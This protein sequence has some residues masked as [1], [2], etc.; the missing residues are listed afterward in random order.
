MET[1]I[2]HSQKENLHELMPMS[3]PENLPMGLIMYDQDLNVLDWNQQAEVI[4]GFN[5]AEIV[6]KNILDFIVPRDQ[7]TSVEYW[8]RKIAFSNFNI[9]TF[10]RNINKQN[11]FVSCN[12]H[13]T[14]IT[15]DTK[16][17]TGFISLVEKTFA[18]QSNLFSFDNTDILKSFAENSGFNIILNYE[19]QEIEY[20]NPSVLY[21]FS[22]LNNFS[23]E[24]GH[25]LLRFIPQHERFRIIRHFKNC[26]SSRSNV[27][28][29][30]HLQV[31]YGTMLPIQMT[32]YYLNINGRPLYVLT[33]RLPKNENF[34]RTSGVNGKKYTSQLLSNDIVDVQKKNNLE[35]LG[36]LT[37]GVVHE[38]NQ[39][40]GVLRIIL[41]SFKEKLEANTLTREFL[42]ERCEMAQAN[43]TRINELMDEIRIFRREVRCNDIRKVNLLTPLHK[44]L[45]LLKM[46]F[47]SNRINIITDFQDDIPLIVAN[48]KWLTTIF[49]NLL[50]NA[51]HSL[52]QKGAMQ[53]DSNLIGEIKISV[54]NDEERVNLQISDNG[55]GIKSK[56]FDKLFDPFFTT[57]GKQGSGLGLAIVKNY[58]KELNGSIEVDSLEGLYATFTITFP[59]IY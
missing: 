18:D 8:R 20:I 23:M 56:H 12:W 25:E 3:I 32:G 59:R 33:V 29:S 15:D 42:V 45:D 1:I 46:S 48:E 44:V 39:P 41:D 24:R 26:A 10:Y 22:I 27:N 57:K 49:S 50:A 19:T 52:S 34:L 47:A 58:I 37:A 6:G 35:L 14:P 54:W 9:T 51:T 11:E 36:D 43:V 21:S 5:A 7:S 55:V 38:I 4:F 17:I 40:L 16:Q 53:Q 31:G 2:R 30:F 28:I 13:T